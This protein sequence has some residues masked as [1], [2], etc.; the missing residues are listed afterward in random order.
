MQVI[1]KRAFEEALIA[2]EGKRAYVVALYRVLENVNLKTVD[3]LRTLFPLL[4]R[5]KYMN[6]LWVI[7]AGRKHL[8]VLLYIRFD[9]GLV[10]VKKVL[11]K[12]EFEL[13]RGHYERGLLA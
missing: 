5:L 4:S 6:H 3:E 10:Y 7:E 12:Q 11:T 8:V 9:L 13:M 2:H 1:S